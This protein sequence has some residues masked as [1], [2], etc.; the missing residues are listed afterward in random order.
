[1]HAATSSAPPTSRSERAVLGDRVLLIAMGVAALAALALGASR[2]Q[3]ALALTVCLV[4]AGVAGFGRLLLPGAWLRYVYTFVL[5]GLIALHIQL[6]GGQIE[7]HFGVFV[8]LAFLMVYLDWTVV[9]FGAALF[10]VHHIAF[11]RLQ[12]AGLGLFCTTQADFG[13]ILLHAAY[14]VIQASIEMVLAVKMNRAAREGEELA[15][16]MKQ[17]EAD[18]HLRLD[19]GDVPVHTEGGRALAAMLARMNAA[20]AGVRAGGSGV[21]VASNEI[22]D[23]NQDLSQRTEQTAANLQRTHSNMVTLTSTV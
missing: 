20:V 5:V 16:L 1:M 13:R 10:A 2:E 23:G 21:E 22:A 6:A 11:D 8:V 7:Y 4:L 3:S 17:V 18:G 19:L 14:V 9:A 15:A 12:A